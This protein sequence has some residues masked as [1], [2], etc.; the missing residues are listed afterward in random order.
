MII[1]DPVINVIGYRFVAKVLI[2]CN[3]VCH[4]SNFVYYDDLMQHARNILKSIMNG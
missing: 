4:P 1:S 3:L 2:S